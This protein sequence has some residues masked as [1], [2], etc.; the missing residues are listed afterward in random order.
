MEGGEEEGGEGEEKGEAEEEG[1]GEAEGKRKE[2]A[3]KRRE[4]GKRERRETSKP[5]HP[6]TV[7]ESTAPPML[8]HQLWM[9]PTAASTFFTTISLTSATATTV[10]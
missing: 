7:C 2:K 5:S 3:E 10:L 8:K 6:A 4:E 9:V 1:E